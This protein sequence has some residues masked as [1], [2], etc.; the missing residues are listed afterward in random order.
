MHPLWVSFQKGKPVASTRESLTVQFAAICFAVQSFRVLKPV[1]GGTRVS[2]VTDLDLQGPVAQ[3]GRGV[4]GSVAGELTRQF[5]QC[6]A[7]R[8]ET[9]ETAPAASEVRPVGALS[10]ALR[11]LWSALA[12]PFRR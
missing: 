4:V 9:E 11:A 10:L 7:R 12:R 2:L 3:Y 5:A 1:D 8:L 6:L